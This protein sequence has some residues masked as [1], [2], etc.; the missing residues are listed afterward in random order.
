MSY[1]ELALYYDRFMA[2]APYDEWVTFMKEVF[3]KYQLSGKRVADLGCGTGEIAWRIAA[4]NY[5]V[6]AIDNSEN[7]L[8]IA[9]Q[10]ADKQKVPIEFLH[11]DLRELQGLS[12]LDAAV[13]FCDVI[14]Y[15]VEPEDLRKVFQA[16]SESLRIGGLF[17]F[18]VHSISHVEADLIDHTFALEEADCS[19]IW[20]CTAGDMPG[21]MY[22]DLTFFVREKSSELYRRFEETH[23][24]RT[25]DV[26]FY[27]SLLLESGFAVKSVCGDFGLNNPVSDETE[28]IFFIAEKVF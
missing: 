12:E 1:Q 28:R 7:M 23:H 2:D 5:Q 4:E 19:Y 17:V 10:K 15:I 16:T 27:K 3:S 24:Q 18:D 21:E 9:A 20:F 14:N 8:S 6:I 11:Q 22:H 25:Y 26:A 13:S